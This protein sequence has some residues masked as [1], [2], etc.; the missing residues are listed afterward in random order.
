MSALSKIRD[1][2][3]EVFAGT[4]FCLGTILI[5]YGVIMRYV[6][7][8]PVFWVDEISIYILLWG[9]LIGWSMAAKH[10]RHVQVDVLYAIMPRKMQYYVTVFEK[11]VCVFFSFFMIYASYLLWIHYWANQQVS[12]NAQVP[13]W[14][15]F[16]VMPVATFLLGIRYL[17]EFIRIL[18]GKKQFLAAK[19]EGGVHH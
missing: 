18:I 15:V 1:I 8:T 10:K 9:I 3:E 6:F 7:Q 4:F 12:I 11:F 16:L 14:I 2:L 19:Y 13:L 17:E 5:T